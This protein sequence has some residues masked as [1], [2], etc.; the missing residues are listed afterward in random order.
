MKDL[1]LLDL[2]SLTPDLKAEAKSVLEWAQA[3]L[4]KDTFPHANYWE[5]H[6]LLVVS[7]GGE[8]CGF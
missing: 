3:E 8:V 4:K 7:L 5:F 1:L 6:E 2:S